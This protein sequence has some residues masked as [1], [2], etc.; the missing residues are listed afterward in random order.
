MSAYTSENFR[1]DTC[2]EIL[3]K[4]YVVFFVEDRCYKKLNYNSCL[5]RKAF[6]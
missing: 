6:A 5:K 2:E 4:F 3:F 1:L